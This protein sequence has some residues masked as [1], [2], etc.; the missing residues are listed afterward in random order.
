MEKSERPRFLKSVFCALGVVFIE[1][2]QCYGVPYS[3]LWSSCEGG[4]T[5]GGDCDCVYGTGRERSGSDG[6]RGLVDGGVGDGEV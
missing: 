1:Y 3:M 6:L 4:L 5:V 2:G